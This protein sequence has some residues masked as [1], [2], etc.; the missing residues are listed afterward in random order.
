MSRFLD[1]EAIPEEPRFDP[2]GLVGILITFQNRRDTF[3]E[4]NFPYPAPAELSLIGQ[5][6]QLSAV[7][8]EAIINREAV[9]RRLAPGEVFRTRHELRR[10]FHFPDQGCFNIDIHLNLMV[11]L[12]N[13]TG[14]TE[15]SA[16]V[17]HWRNTVEIVIEPG[18]GSGSDHQLRQFA[19]DLLGDGD[20]RRAEAVE[21]FA[22]IGNETA[23][24]YLREALGMSEVRAEALQGLARIGSP[25]SLALI[26]DALSDSDLPS[27]Q[28]GLSSLG[29]AG[30]P[31]QLATL[32]ALVSS[33]DPAVHYACL[34]HL[35]GV[36]THEHAAVVEALVDSPNNAVAELARRFLSRF[37]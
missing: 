17:V 28:V 32:R 5:S 6:A 11:Q 2:R 1:I 22:H 8:D 30:S 34:E 31:I 16:E 35:L 18:V 27:L 37:P 26:E 20:Q 15:G 24:P 10:Y 21:A 7:V 36:G 9:P 23:L 29:T 12:V 25:S 3:I 13:R 33:G 19:A 4:F 14:E